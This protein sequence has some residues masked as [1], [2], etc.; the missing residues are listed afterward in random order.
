M[1]RES[2]MAVSSLVQQLGLPGSDDTMGAAIS[3]SPTRPDDEF[4]QPRARIREH[5]VARPHA[6]TR[7]SRNGQFDE[8]AAVDI[9]CGLGGL[10]EGL[11]MAGFDV[12]LGI[13]SSPSAARTYQ[14]N[15]PDALVALQELTQL[16]KFRSYLDAVGIGQ[17]HLAVLAGGTPCQSFSAANTKKRPGRNEHHNLVLEFARLVKEANPALF[18]LEN[19]PRMASAEKGELLKEFL[20]IVE[21]AGYNVKK[22]TLRASDFGVPQTR[23]RLFVVGSRIGR[24]EFMD[25]THGPESHSGKKF[26]TVEDAII[27]DLP[28]AVRREDVDGSMDYLGPAT[29]WYQRWCR[30]GSREVTDH[31]WNNLG[32]DPLRRFA[33]IPPGKSWVQ[34]QNA[35]LAPPELE[36]RIDHRSVYRRLEADEPA[37]TI[38]HFRKAM[39]IHPTEDR[40]ITLREAARLQSFRDRFS[41]TKKGGRMT[42]MD[43]LQQ[44][45]ANA[46]PPL[47]ARAVGRRLRSR[48]AR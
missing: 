40:L 34:I 3:E 30:V 19:V 38:V 33:L 43:E 22:S 12:R 39:T 11:A 27:G 41:F 16:R 47:L 14:L 17:G 46:V 15:H 37:V 8:L 20:S 9:C 23:R 36:I 26:V 4:S 28:S 18:V 6:S 42:Q 44:Q 7:R 2:E 29:N 32:V 31:F 48:L 35:G 24:F 5:G 21:Q 1:A 13:D 25:P 45:L 10:S